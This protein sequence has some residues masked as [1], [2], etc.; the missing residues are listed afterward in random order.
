MTQT[1]NRFQ[2]D[3]DRQALTPCERSCEWVDA[4]RRR[5]DPAVGHNLVRFTPDFT[6]GEA[7]ATTAQR[8]LIAE[9]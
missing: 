8:A 5:E 1:P 7:F 9:S 2:T 6:P 3:A 4:Y